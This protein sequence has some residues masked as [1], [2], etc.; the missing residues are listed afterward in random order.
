MTTYRTIRKSFDVLLP[1]RRVLL[2]ALLWVGV[3]IVAGGQPHDAR[4]EAASSAEA[5][6]LMELVVVNPTELRLTG[7]FGRAGLR[8]VSDLYVAG[9]YD[10]ALE[11]Y[12]DHFL[13]RLAA[14][15]VDSAFRLYHPPNL[16]TKAADALMDGKML[17]GGK[18]V[19]I[20]E[21]G[22]VNWTYPL[23]NG[24]PVAYLEFPSADLFTGLGFAPLLEAYVTKRDRRYLDRWVAYMEDWCV[25]ER[26]LAGLHGCLVP[27]VVNARMCDGVMSFTAQLGRFARA[28]LPPAESIPP[29]TFMRVIR[30][31]LRDLPLTSVAY[32]RSNPHN[33]TPT[34]LH[35]GIAFAYDEFRWAPLIMREGRRRNIEDNAVTQNL[36]DGS[37][38]QQ[39]P[40]YNDNYVKA[41]HSL[42]KL[43]EFRDGQ[44]SW[45][46]PFWARAWTE[47]LDARDE[48]SD[49]LADRVAFQVHLRTA[50]N[51][52]P[53]PFRGGDKRYAGFASYSVSPEAYRRPDVRGILRALGDATFDPGFTDEWFPYGGYNIVRDGWRTGARS[54]HAAMFSSP[55]P[56]SYGAYRSRGN[57]NVFGLE[58][59]DQDLLVDDTTGH[60]MYPSSPIRVDGKDQFFHAKYNIYKVPDPANHKTYM[61][62]AWLEPA[63]WRWH[64][65]PRFNLMEGVYDGPYGTVEKVSILGNYGP[66]EA[67][68]ATLSAEESMHGLTHQ[69]LALYVREPRLWILADR[70]SAQHSHAYEQV[71]WIPTSPGG[72]A[73]FATNEI[74]VD[75]AGQS[76]YTVATSNQ[77]SDRNRSPALANMTMRQFSPAPLAYA[78]KN[79]PRAPIADGR[80]MV[81]GLERVSASWTG[82]GAQQVV[83]AVWPRPLDTEPMHGFAEMKPLS[84][85]GRADGFEARTTNGVMIRFLSARAGAQELALGEVRATAEALLL[86]GDK[87]MALGVTSMRVGDRAVPVPHPDFEFALEGRKLA[88]VIPIHRPIDPVIIGPAANVFDESVDVKLASR[89][90]GVEIRYTL[91]GTDPTPQSALYTGRLVLTQSSVV[92]ARAYRPGLFENP[93]HTSGTH[94]TPVSRARFERTARLAPVNPKK[95][96]ENGLA[97][98]YWEGPWRELWLDH[99]RMAPLATGTVQALWEAS[100]FSPGNPPVGEQASPRARPYLV[101]YAGYLDVPADGVYTFHAPREWTMPDTEAGYDLQVHLGEQRVPW[102]WRTEAAGLKQWYPST[103]IHGF[104][105]W[106]I[107]LQKGLHP[108]RVTFLDYRTDAASKM[109]KPGLRDYIWTGAFPDLKLSGPGL[110][111]APIPSDWLR[112]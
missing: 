87:G 96:V 44:A 70:L 100:V 86:H 32:S 78:R 33:W 101:E 69:R 7:L 82:A 36:R 77:P 9:D 20:G 26:Y 23:T 24:Y 103:R 89:T 92:K 48:M 61:V 43:F 84:A 41:I 63:P 64:A 17:I 1:R 22:S 10:A 67:R 14:I 91:D 62:S 94:A 21:P 38:N 39:C 19:A 25:N 56:G 6:D 37:E 66:E 71:W 57:N 60:Y 35:V 8:K 90:P 11:A 76:L 105:T 52:W 74:V 46:E 109:N 58:A 99:A 34:A 40:W 104:G 106:S 59:D 13:G 18:E 5:R 108:F 4:A 16:D 30:K 75:A 85:D 29:R 65:S 54:G 50:R 79:Q 55:M 80:V 112:R 12:R 73:A 49:H 110:A 27:S 31:Y 3:W 97:V 98:R 107:N 111:A 15:P 81:Y 28:G 53:I 95:N 68:Q 2:A 45:T 93:K 72:N 83:S 102:G 88:Q 47:D 51:E 42:F